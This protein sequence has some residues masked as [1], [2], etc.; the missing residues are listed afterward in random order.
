MVVGLDDVYEWNGLDADYQPGGGSLVA[1]K[2]IKVQQRLQLEVEG[3]RR[4]QREMLEVRG[5]R[6]NG[7][8]LP[9]LQDQLWLDSGQ[10]IRRYLLTAEPV[11]GDNQLEWVME[12]SRTLKHAS[13]VGGVR[14]TG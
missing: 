4:I 1:V 11:G 9:A 7:F 8:P 5:R 10:G 14:Y 13:G 2:V 6:Y 12:F 3:E